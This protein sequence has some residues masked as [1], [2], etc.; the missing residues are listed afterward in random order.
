MPVHFPN[1]EPI[2]FVQQY[3]SVPFSAAFI[4][5]TDNYT[6]K[7]LGLRERHESKMLL[8]KETP[9][10]KVNSIFSEIA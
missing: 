3:M 8:L 1:M 5:T 2:L 7:V 6:S 10:K 9:L 4:T